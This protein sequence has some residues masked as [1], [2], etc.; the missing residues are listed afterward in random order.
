[1]IR[2]L[3]ADDHAMVRQGL[4][5]LLQREGFE[6][7]GEAADGQEAVRLA[8]ESCPDAWAALVSTPSASSRGR[9]AS[10]WAS[11]GTRMTPSHWQW[12]TRRSDTPRD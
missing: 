11:V 4:L 7:V 5:L 12:Q 2:I 1:M 6:V 9:K 3:L 10:Q 8:T